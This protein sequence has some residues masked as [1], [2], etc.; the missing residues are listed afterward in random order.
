M[1]T[2]SNTQ[3]HTY[4][5]STVKLKQL[6][7]FVT[8][9]ELRVLIEGLNT[10]QQTNRDSAADWWDKAEISKAEGNKKD[11]DAQCEMSELFSR[12]AHTFRRLTKRAEELRN[13]EEADAKVR[14]ERAERTGDGQ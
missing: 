3:T 1:S 5:G 6:P 12:T 7:L 14:A 9:T 2:I 4:N 13:A 11:A 8:I 10:L